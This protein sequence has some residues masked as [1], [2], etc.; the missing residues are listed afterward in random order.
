MKK[1]VLFALLPPYADWESAFIAS[2]L[3][4]G[5]NGN[6][7]PYLV[8]TLA[9]TKEPLQSCGGFTIL[10]DYDINC[11]PK[12]Y[13]ALI[14]IGGK[15]WFSKERKET[16]E[17]KQIAPIVQNALDRNI[18]VGA[19]CDASAFLGVHGWLNQKYHTSNTLEDL[20]TV[21][22]KNYTNEARYVSKQAVRDGNLITANGTAYLEFTRKILLALEAY[23][24]EDIKTHYNFYKYGCY[25]MMKKD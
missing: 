25:E 14:L 9:L 21:A 17:A 5:I 10:P 7:S 13:S 19:I 15:S 18:V 3:N 2:A 23:S 6:T 20:K 12:N 1:E 24:R 11:I 16:E 8:K 22:G 4:D